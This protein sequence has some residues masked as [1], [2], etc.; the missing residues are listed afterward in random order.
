MMTSRIELC[1]SLRS[2][3]DNDEQTND[4]ELGAVTFPVAIPL[5][6]IA[7]QQNKTMKKFL[8]LGCLLLSF[9]TAAGFV[10]PVPS[11]ARTLKPA[12][13]S[14]FP[15]ENTLFSRDVPPSSSTALAY[16]VSPEPIH[17]AF[18]VANFGEKPFRVLG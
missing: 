16:T 15:Q 1:Q 5:L 4:Q 18:N 17:T 10:A 13:Q 11:T 7:W 3:V 2:R 12:T 8:L 6:S 9:Q 14:V